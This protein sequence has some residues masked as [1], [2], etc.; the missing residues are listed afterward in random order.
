[1]WPTRSSITSSGTGT[2]VGKSITAGVPT[3]DGA[4]IVS[5][6]V[7]AGLGLGVP[8][9]T[10]LD[11]ADGDAAG[12]TVALGRTVAVGTPVRVAV[13]IP[14]CVA[15]RIPDRVAVGLVGAAVGVD[16][17]QAARTTAPER[18]STRCDNAQRTIGIL[19]TRW[20]P[21]YPHH[22]VEGNHPGQPGFTGRVGQ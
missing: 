10:V 16:V 22:R 6:R 11:V 18:A 1:M 2:T 19:Q 13:R 20:L 21:W 14:G 15:V 3:P 5:A 7:G 9:G 4:V 12:A 8:V 17:P